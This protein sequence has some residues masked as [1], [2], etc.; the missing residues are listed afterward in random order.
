MYCRT[1]NAAENEVYKLI[2]KIEWGFFGH[3]RLFLRHF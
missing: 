3:F 2:E 1:E